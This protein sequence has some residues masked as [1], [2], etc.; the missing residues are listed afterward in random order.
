MIHPLLPLIGFYLPNPTMPH[1]FLLNSD[2]VRIRRFGCLLESNGLRGIAGGEGQF[3]DGG[4]HGGNDG[5]VGRSVWEGDWAGQGQGE[6]EIA[7]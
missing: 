4:G 3:S 5:A 7:Q 2:K 1:G 6:A